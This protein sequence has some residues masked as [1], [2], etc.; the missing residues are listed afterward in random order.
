MIWRNL[1]AICCALLAAALGS[2]PIALAQAPSQQPILRIDT[3]Q[4][5]ATI[6]D[7]AI[8]P[9]GAVVATTGD[10]KTIRLWDPRT[11][12]LIDTLRIPIGEGAEGVLYSL[13]FAPSGRSLLVGGISGLEWDQRNYLYV[14]RPGE[15]RIAG[16]LPLGGVLRR[17]VYSTAGGET[18]LALAL[19]AADGGA[20]QVRDAR[21]R[22]I[23]EDLDLSGAPSWI[24]FGHDGSLVAALSGGELRIYDKSFSVRSTRLSGLEPSIARLSPDGGVIAVGY[25][26]RRHID[27]VS[28]SSLKVIRQLSGRLDGG[29]P[30]LN[31]LTWVV[32]GGRQEL[33]AGGGYSDTQGRIILRRWPDIGKPG[34]YQDLPVAQD[35]ITVLETTSAGD[36]IFASGDPRWGVVGADF[37]LRRQVPRPGP[38]YRLVYD[39]VFGVAPDG[40]QIAF[41]YDGAGDVGS[42][43]FD[44]ADQRLEKL[45]A[46]ALRRVR[47][48]FLLPEVPGGLTDW[49]ISET[50]RFRG[51]ALPLRPR[52]RSLST[53]ALPGGGFVLGADQTLSVFDDDGERLA[54][55]ELSS[56]VFGVAAFSD[57]RMLAAMGD[58]S[59]RWFA[60]EGDQIVEQGALYVERARLRW[61]AWLPDGRFN[62]SANG[63]Q[64]LAGYHTNR[65]ANELA[66]WTD[67]SQLYRSYYAPEAVV[68]QLLGQT[69]AKATVPA[70]VESAAAAVTEA[71]A[72][73]IELLE[74]CPVTG[75]AIGAC[76]PAVLATRGLGAIEAT[77]SSDPATAFQ[78]GIRTFPADVERVLI[79]YRITDA[80]HGIDKIDVFRNERTTGQTRGLGQIGRSDP[81]ITEIEGAREVFLLE[82]VNALQVRAYDGRGVY[83]KSQTL[84]L[85]RLAPEQAVLPNLHVLVIGANTYG[86]PFGPLTYARP[87]AETVARLISEAKPDAYNEVF[88]TDLIDAAASRE[89]VARALEELA[90]RSRPEDAV[91]VYVA[92][93]GY[94]DTAGAY[95][96]IP[97]GIES[98]DTIEGRT[99]D[100]G[101]LIE[102]LSNVQ[103]ENLMLLLDTCYAGAFPASAAGNINNETGFMVLTASTSY[104]EALDSHD[105]NNGVFVF[106][107]KEAL[108]GRISSPDGVADALTLGDYVRKRVRQLAAERSHSQKPQLLIGNSDT[109][110]PVARI[111]VASLD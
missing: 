76:A 25:H 36:V 10:D 19:S 23:A 65:S 20:I 87:D 22:L 102:K 13:A 85:R 38:D 80:T 100:Q 6:H 75:D 72:P 17:V 5:Q 21:A 24:D 67:F 94:R 45:D 28:A 96:F 70:P 37:T 84:T 105:G 26:D 7:V 68:A 9:D 104:E 86:A 4:H 2:C 62:H 57:G 81:Q 79:K 92:G 90:K 43:I 8:S 107:L 3:A 78:D 50:P 42:F 1:A 15:R 99:V 93:H 61:L 98:L 88:V 14:L 103:V 48:T 11:G 44:I 110:F 95:H 56:A 111:G 73:T 31:A 82:G 109:P 60:R 63:G 35:T 74:I 52:E 16:R 33:W 30:S 53:A 51:R 46:V 71:P 101:M 64:E 40:S 83:G 58:G 59:L 97:P 55:R 66:N 108:A 106:A 41:R 18:R 29:A 39:G 69:V 54:E 89:G 77:T 27:L 34:L 47:E 91:L 49:R 32:R 12:T